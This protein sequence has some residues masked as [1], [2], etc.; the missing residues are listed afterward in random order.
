MVLV[1]GEVKLWPERIRKMFWTKNLC[2][3]DMIVLIAF[4]EV[5][6]LNPVIFFKWLDLLGCLKDADARRHIQYLFRAFN[7]RK[8][9]RSLYN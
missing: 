7:E 6:G 1:L 4:V 8:Y 3:W 5:N 2:H 9:A